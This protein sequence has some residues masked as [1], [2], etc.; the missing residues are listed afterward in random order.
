[1]SWSDAIIWC[2]ALSEKEGLDPVY[3]Y[4]GKVLR[5][6]LDVT[7]SENPD[8][9]MKNNGYRLPTEAEWEFA[10]RGGDIEAS[11]WNFGFAGTDDIEN[12]G[13]Y[14]WYRGNSSLFNIGSSGEIIDIHPIGQKKPNRLGLYDMSGNCWEWCFDRYNQRKT[15]QFI[16]PINKDG[17]RHRIIK[18]GSVKHGLSFSRVKS[19]GYAIPVNP[20]YILGFRLAQTI[21]NNN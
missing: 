18:S 15:G 13:D 10:A 20:G 16:D 12:A 1:M 2:N 11:D 7:K 21:D 4:D 19:W 14:V 3:Y 5:N 8:V 17:A 6:A 9:R